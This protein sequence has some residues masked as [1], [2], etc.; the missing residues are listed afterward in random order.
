MCQ[1]RGVSSDGGDERCSLQGNVEQIRNDDQLGHERDFRPGG[2]AETPEINTRDR[3]G[4]ST[5][6]VDVSCYS[7]S[8]SAYL[9]RER[10]CKV[11]D[12]IAAEL[13]RLMFL[14]NLNSFQHIKRDVGL[15][16]QHEERSNKHQDSLQRISEYK[17]PLRIIT[18]PEYMWKMCQYPHL[19]ADWSLFIKV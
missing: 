19:V 16:M 15:K 11:V 7:E 9:S 8:T 1:P 2:E 3:E 4:A 18:F 5:P 6:Y 17:R 12:W 14:P 10:S 13:L